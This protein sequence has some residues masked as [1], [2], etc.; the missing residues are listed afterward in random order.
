MKLIQE[1]GPF[2][3]LKVYINVVFEQKRPPSTF[4]AFSKKKSNLHVYLFP[5]PRLVILHFL[6]P[7]HVY[8]RDESS[9]YLKIDLFNKP[10]W[11]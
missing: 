8:Y 6:H 10:Q 4:I 7:L 1:I 3:A 9:P 11:K 5:P 2:F